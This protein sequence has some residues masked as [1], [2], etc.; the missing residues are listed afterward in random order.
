[1]KYSG[2]HA[3]IKYAKIQRA[4][5]NC[6]LLKLKIPEYREPN[7]SNT[8]GSS[9]TINFHLSR[10]EKPY[11]KR[12]KYSEFCR[13]ASLHVSM[14][15]LFKARYDNEVPKRQNWQNDKMA[16]I[17]RAGKAKK[18]VMPVA[19]LTKR[20]IRAKGKKCSKCANKGAIK[21]TKF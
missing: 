9:I 6:S 10:G 5:F 7:K 14:L 12:K 1:M 21:M 4:S 2:S 15:K 17:A 8:K 19:R 20:K 3:Q 13:R 16:K 11:F 18:C